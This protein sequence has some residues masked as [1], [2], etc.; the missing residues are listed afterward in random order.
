MECIWFLF[1]WCPPLSVDCFHKLCLSVTPSENSQAG[2]DLANRMARVIGL[3][4][5]ESVPWKVMPEVFK[6]SVRE[7]SWRHLKSNIFLLLTKFLRIKLSLYVCVCIYIYLS[8]SGEKTTPLSKKNFDMMSKYSEILSFCSS[9]K[10]CGDYV[11]SALF[12][13]GI[14]VD[15]F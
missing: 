11:V 7:M 9:L 4:W 15:C 3:T 1:W 5:N 10:W 8:Y 2:W 14:Q 12:Q 13:W 6:C